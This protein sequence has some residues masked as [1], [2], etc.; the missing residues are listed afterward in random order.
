MLSKMVFSSRL[1]LLCL[2]CFL[3]SL[4][5][6]SVCLFVCL[7]RLLVGATKR[8]SAIFLHRLYHRVNLHFKDQ[9]LSKKSIKYF[10]L[11]LTILA[12]SMFPKDST[13]M[14]AKISTGLTAIM[15]SSRSQSLCYKPTNT[16]TTCS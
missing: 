14:S 1:Y 7:F 10:C 2:F 16:T 6:F 3:A 4:L 9:K 11:N 8:C 13:Y 5:L 12:S 15:K